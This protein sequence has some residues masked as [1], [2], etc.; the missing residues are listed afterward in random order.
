M[1]AGEIAARLALQAEAV[2]AYLLPNGKRSGL[3]W[4]AG[5]VQG[6]AG[7]SLKVILS[8]SRVGKWTDYADDSHNGDLLDLWADCHGISIQHAINQAKDYL[9]IRDPVRPLP[10]AIRQT[11]PATPAKSIARVNPS[12]E[13]FRYLTE[14]RKLSAAII[15]KF[16]IAE[17]QDQARGPVIVFP[18][19][20]DGQRVLIKYLP[21]RREGKKAP[22]TSKD[23][24]KILFG[25]QT[26]PD[27]CRT[28]VLTEGEIDAMSLA[29]F[30][31]PALS[32]PYGAGKQSQS[33]W[34]E[35]DF[36]YLEQFDEIIIWMDSDEAGRTAAN[37]IA[38]RLGIER[39]RL[40]F[41][42]HDCNDINEMLQKGCEEIH[43]RDCLKAAKAIEPD[44]LRG[45]ESYCAEVISE[46][47]P[48]GGQ[49]PAIRLGWKNC[50]WLM[51]RP[52]ELIIISGLNGHGK[53]QLAG[54]FMLQAMADS[55]RCVIASMELPARRLLHR[56]TKQ[57]AALGDPTAEY[58][59][60]IHQWYSNK[61]WL[62]DR[63]GRVDIDQ[64]LEA[65][66]Y[67]HRRYGCDVFLIDSLM[68]CGIRSDDWAEQKNFVERL[69]EWKLDNVATIF[70]VTHSRK[71]Q[72]ESNQPGKMD[73]RG[74][75]EI[76]D[77]ADTVLTCWRNK[78]E[79]KKGN[80]VD[81][82][83]DCTKQRNSGDEGKIPVWF[84]KSS[85]QFLPYPGARPWRFVNFSVDSSSQART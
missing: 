63:V 13:V 54:Q 55:H 50:E 43:F 9:G 23:S 40:A 67:A 26:L 25:W 57:A 71:Q 79:K 70:L 31:V 66:T 64:M 21:V 27:N 82:L 18:F 77:L 62:Y 3:Y 47:Y 48:E 36:D 17:L 42:S 4:L 16:Q 72:N 84:D 7:Q 56:L 83:I 12:G 76:T 39:C 49:E 46:F 73:V 51:F 59:T 33:E 10:A 68:M 34:I 5:S 11:V 75:G 61:L 53:S 65:F 35:N 85:T 15:A 37:E 58:I 45:A 22:W 20:K 44:H 32:I 8:G 52:A 74:A 38:H 80:D 28:V 6:E 2:A 24:A 1:R 29:M 60:A 41:A 30:G 14:E 69:M 81:G 19:L 78:D